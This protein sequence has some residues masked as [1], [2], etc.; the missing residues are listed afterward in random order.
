MSVKVEGDVSVERV[1]NAELW[2]VCDT[3]IDYW[4]YTRFGRR[5]RFAFIKRKS[6]SEED[7]TKLMNCLRNAL[8]ENVRVNLVIEKRKKPT[9]TSTYEDYVQKAEYSHHNG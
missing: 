7:F 4:D 2:V 6:F 9:T 5:H 8:F 3:Y 1:T